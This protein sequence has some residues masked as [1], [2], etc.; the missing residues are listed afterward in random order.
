MSSSIVLSQVVL[1]PVTYR[2]PPVSWRSKCG[3]NDMV[4]VLLGSGTSKA[5]KETQLE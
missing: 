5:P 3:G 2:P 1:G 4:M